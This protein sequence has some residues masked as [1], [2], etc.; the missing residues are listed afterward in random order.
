MSNFRPIDRA[1][2]CLLPPSVDEW[3][4]DDQLARIVFEIVEQLDLSGMERAY[5][6]ASKASYHPAMLTA[7][8]LCGYATGRRSAGASSPLIARRRNQHY[9]PWFDRMTTPALDDAA[10]GGRAD[11][12]PP[13]HSTG[14]V[15]IRATQTDRR[16]GV[17]HH[18]VGDALPSIP[19]A[20]EP[21]GR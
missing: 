8:L 3:L 13:A 19:V 1:T 14:M 20:R 2:L 16:T 18:Q 6:G 12:P 5:R 15:L 17:R 11:D 4:P 21:E 7:L 10:G 9:A